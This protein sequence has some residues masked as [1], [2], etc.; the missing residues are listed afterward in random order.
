MDFNNFTTV[1]WDKH[2]PKKDYRKVFNQTVNSY[3]TYK[4]YGSLFK[5]VADFLNS[6]IHYVTKMRG[7][8]AYTNYEYYEN[9]TYDAF[10]VILKGDSTLC[11]E[12][13][14]KLIIGSTIPFATIEEVLENIKSRE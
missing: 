6:E 2:D 3:E 11:T 12:D 4:R 1:Y 8:W 14:L 10:M 9:T 7:V 13:M 5:D